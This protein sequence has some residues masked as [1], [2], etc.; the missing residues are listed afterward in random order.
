MRLLVAVMGSTGSGKTELA[1]ALA[2]ELSAR[3]INSDNFQAYRYLDIGTA[4]PDA[5]GRYELL[6]ILDP[7]EP[8]GV[9][10]WVKMTG[11]V[12][13]SA[14]ENHIVVGGSGLNV[15]ALFEGYE[16]MAGP[17]PDG[18][19]DE[20]NAR[21]LDSLVAELAQRAPELAKKV[22]TQN[23]VR[24]R[25]ALERLES[26]VEPVHIDLSGYQ[27]VKIGLDAPPEWV[28]P[29]IEQRVHSML[30]AGWLKEVDEVKAMGFGYDAPGL[31]AHGYRNL[32]DVLEGRKDLNQAIDEIVAMVRQYAKRQRTWMRGEPKLC[33]ISAV[34]GR[35]AVTDALSAIRDWGMSHGK[36]D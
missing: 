9:G 36:V 28:N 17:P 15:R 12:I 31:R 35:G 2:D 6:D 8:F 10:A 22:D 24:V 26:E 18:L 16:G 14:K 21:S 30:E 13:S 11:E 23:P 20:L 19:R 7:N 27:T 25:R 1:E 34:N 5:R 29:R 32:W 4:K 3:L 33:K